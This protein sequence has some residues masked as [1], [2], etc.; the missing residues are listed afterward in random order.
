MWL[1][2]GFAEQGRHSAAHVGHSGL[3]AWARAEGVSWVIVV[4]GISTGSWVSH[5][6]TSQPFLWSFWEASATHNLGVLQVIVT[7]CINLVTSEL[8]SNTQLS[9][10][11]DYGCT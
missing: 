2:D 3:A 6:L 8:L 4:Q 1:A 11:A 10:P 5:R 7:T 9:L